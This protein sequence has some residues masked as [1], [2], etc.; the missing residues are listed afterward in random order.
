MNS[1]ISI[2]LLVGPTSRAIAG[3]TV[4]PSHNLTLN[5]EY[6]GITFGST[7]TCSKPRPCIA[8][9]RIEKKQL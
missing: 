6:S 9:L 7:E 4:H 2:N 5:L 8:S 1:F 3:T